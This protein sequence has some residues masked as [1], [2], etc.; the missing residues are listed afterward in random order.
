MCPEVDSAS[1]NEYQDTT[2]GKDLTTFIV[3]KVMNICSL[4]IPDPQESL[5]ACSWENLYLFNIVLQ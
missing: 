1:K 3:L 2:G 4:N 5:R